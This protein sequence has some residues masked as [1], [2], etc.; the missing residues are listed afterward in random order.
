MGKGSIILA[1]LVLGGLA[2]WYWSG[3]EPD[4]F[5]ESQA[6]ALAEK[7]LLDFCASEEMMFLDFKLKAEEPAVDTRF[8][9]SYRFDNLKTE[10]ARRILISV[11]KKGDYSVA[12]E[13]F[14]PDPAELALAQYQASTSSG[15]PAE[16]GAPAEGA[17]AEGAAPPGE[18]A[19]AAG[20]GAP[21]GEGVPQGEAAP[22]EA[23]P[24]EAAPVPQ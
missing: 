9:W 17:P 13:T 1:V 6:K 15:A 20:E 7:T 11:G 21:P 24:A 5:L 18:S 22:A 3:R 2:A 14:T 4:D 12:F 19:P 8:K 10:P 23:P 16:A